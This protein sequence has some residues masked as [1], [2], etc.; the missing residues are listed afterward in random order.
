MKELIIIGAGPAGLTAAIY[1]MRSGLDL[2]VIEKFAPGGQVVNTWEVENYPGFPEPIAGWD[3]VAKMEEQARRLGAEIISGDVE[4]LSKENGVFRVGIAGGDTLEARAVIVTAGASLRTL[5]IPGEAKFT[6]RGVSYCATCDAA[7]FR[8]KKTVVI[9]GG[10]VALEEAV[11]LTRF[12]ERVYLVHRRDRFRADSIQVDRVLACENI[13]PVY[14]SVP[15]KIN[16]N[17]K[18]DS[19]TLKNVKSGVETDIE[20]DGVFIFVGFDPNTGFLPAEILNEHNEVIVDISMRTPIEGLFAAGDIR[21]S[22]IRQIACAT[23][24]AAVAASGAY[25]YITGAP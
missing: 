16:G 13:E 19:I 11:F 5:G 21:A 10:N 15:V 1:G 22:S 7:F 18:I 17:D 2:A 14:D 25:Y 20:T 9:G 3:L 24:D 8:D 12:A 4:T 6:G 23:G